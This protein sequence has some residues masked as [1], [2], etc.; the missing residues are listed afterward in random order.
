[1]AIAARHGC[2]A[3]RSLLRDPGFADDL[4]RLRQRSVA[5][6]TDLAAYHWVE[7]AFAAFLDAKYEL[8]IEAGVDRDHVTRVIGAVRE[9]RRDEAEPDTRRRVQHMRLAKDTTCELARHAPAWADVERRRS[10]LA[11]TGTGLE[12]AWA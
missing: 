2:E 4:Q 1:M 9:W 12:H 5:C 7:Q 3:R 8:P 6:H 10:L 11:D